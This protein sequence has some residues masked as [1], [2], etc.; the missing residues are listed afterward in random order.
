MATKEQIVKLTTTRFGTV[1]VLDKEIVFF[2]FGVFGFPEDR[3]YLLLDHDENTPLKWLQ[4]VDKPEL[5]FPIVQATDIVEDYRITVPPDE[6]AALG[7]EAIAEV[8]AYV[9]LTIPQGAPERT[10]ANL[11]APILMNPTTHLA[12]QVLVAEDYPIRY[13]LSQTQPVTTGCAG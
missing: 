12:R 8:H 9:I 7:I 6:L 3:R 13:T 1:E 5:A 11:K 2:S 4:A 10:T